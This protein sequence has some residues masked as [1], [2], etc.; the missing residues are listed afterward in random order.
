MFLNAAPA[1]AGLA[2]IL[3]ILDFPN[4]LALNSGQ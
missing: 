3:M 4:F 2:S 1:V